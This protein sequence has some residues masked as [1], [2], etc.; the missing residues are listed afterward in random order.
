MPL[1]FYQFLSVVEM[2]SHFPPNI[3]NKLSEWERE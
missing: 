2:K 3:V 1:K